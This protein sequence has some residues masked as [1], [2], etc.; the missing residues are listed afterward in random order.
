[1]RIYH[2]ARAADWAEATRAGTYQI[3]TLGRSLAEE[4]FIHAA[5]RDQV[6]E[7]HRR[8]Y[9]GVRDPLV[10]LTI[11]TERLDAPWR[12]ETAGGDVYPHIYGA[13]N[14]TA[15]IA[16]QPLSRRGGTEP[17]LVI[18]FREAMARI[19]V[20]LAVMACA[21]VG[22]LLLPRWFPG[23]WANFGGAAAG[24]AAGGLLAWLW[25]RRTSR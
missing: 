4:G 3:S 25:V 19:L 7:V 6:P 8:H 12:E 24:I 21:A 13:L 14:P 1:M 15:V 10:L 2:I 9:R 5:R 22:S 23:E 20:A 17:F 18:F 16:A 11:D